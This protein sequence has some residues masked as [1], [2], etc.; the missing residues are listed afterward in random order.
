MAVLVVA[1]NQMRGDTSPSPL[2]TTN[3]K[4]TIPSLPYY[5]SH[6]HCSPPPPSLS[7]TPFTPPIQTSVPSHPKTHPPSLPVPIHILT[8]Q[9]H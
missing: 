9:H 8:L 1:N 6:S 4:V 2:S 7:L 5:H 3:L